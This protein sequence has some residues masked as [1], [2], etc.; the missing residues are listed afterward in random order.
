MKLQYIFTLLLSV[1]WVLQVT[2]QQV[3]IRNY[4]ISGLIISETT[5]EAIPYVRIQVNRTRRGQLSNAEGFYSIPVTEDDT[6]YFSHVGFHPTSFVVRDY[7]QSYKGDLSQYIYVVNYMLED[8]FSLK[9]IT[10]FPYNTPEEI[11]TAVINMDILEDSPQ[12]I[13][14]RNL[15]PEVLDAI[16]QTLPKDG[17]ERLLVARQVYQEEYQN[18]NLLRTAAIN[19]LAAMRLLQYVVQ[20][21]KKRKNKDLNYWE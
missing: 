12:A 20:K 19:P 16:I 14:R 11:R 6:L 5:D 21:S 8:T 1:F 3:P 17:N 10:I 13:A 2:A 7:L 4:Q 9:P 15:D 18:R